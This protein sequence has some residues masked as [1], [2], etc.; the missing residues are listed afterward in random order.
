[1]R[2]TE[3]PICFDLNP[4]ALG[5]I[6]GSRMKNRGSN[7]SKLDIRLVLLWNSSEIGLKC[8][9][10]RFEVLYLDKHDYISKWTQRFVVLQKVRF[11]DENAEIAG[12]LPMLRD[13]QYILH[14]PCLSRRLGRKV[15][16]SSQNR[17]RACRQYSI[18]N[19]NKL[20][21]WMAR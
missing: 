11:M 6:W 21:I 14:P 10:L 3:E 15:S 12:W 19:R 5:R 4:C 13:L 2:P 9:A 16:T 1:M 17:L 18:F 7:R 8:I 20:D